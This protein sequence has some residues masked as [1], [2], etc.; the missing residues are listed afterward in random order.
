MKKSCLLAFAIAGV[1]V[2]CSEDELVSENVSN[3]TREIPIEFSVQKENVTRA[4]NLETVKHYNFGVWAYKVNGKNSLNDVLV[5]ENYLVGYSDGSSKGYDKSGAT[6]WANAAGTQTDHTA[7]WFYEGLGTDEYTY[8]DNAGF[9]TTSSTN[10]LSNNKN[11]YLRYW[12]LAYATTNFYAYAPYVHNEGTD[13]VVTFNHVQNGTSTMTFAANTIRD[14]Y[15]N[16]I[17]TAY[18]EYDRSLSEFMYAGVKA[19][20]SDLKDVT[21]PFKHMGAQVGIRFYEDIPGYK[22]EIINLGDDYGT[23]KTGEGITDDMSKGIQLTPSV[24]PANATDKYTPGKYYTTSG[25]TVSFNENNVSSENANFTPNYDGSTKVSTPLMFAVP[26]AGLTDFVDLNNTTHK[27]IKEASTDSQTEFS[28]SPTIYYA[29]AQ[30]K[31]NATEFTKSGFTIHVSYRIIAED[32][33]EVITVHNATV[34]IPYKDNNQ[35]I[36]IW[37]PNTKYTYTFKITKNSTGTTNPDTE[38]DPTDPTPSDV[39]ALYPI[40]FDE[41][42]IED[43]T[44]LENET[45]HNDND[46]KY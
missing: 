30:P 16:T 38:I 44:P 26:N 31:E 18:N 46:T 5:M 42:T 27:V 45:T 2:G 8:A 36:T 22:V 20:N 19:T 39:K 35:L 6:T 4:A 32:N 23:M 1:L 40:V 28:N 11:Q 25:A 15:D 12:D 37:E 7:P 33:K 17:N 14:G 9:Y 29:V 21:V 13:K 10:Y 24:A 3:L 43:Y 41:A 34:H